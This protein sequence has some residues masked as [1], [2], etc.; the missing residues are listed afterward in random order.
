[1]N[2]PYRLDVRLAIVVTAVSAL[3]LF[4]AGTF[5]TLEFTRNQFALEER[6]L[7]A[8]V[9]ER[10]GLIRRGSDGAIA[11]D[12]SAEPDHVVEFAQARRQSGA[13][14]S[15]GY[16]VVNQ[17]GHILDRSRAKVPIGRPGPVTSKPVISSAPA[18]DGSGP[19]LVAELYAPQAGVWLRVTRARSDVTALTNSFFVRLVGNLGWAALAILLVLVLTA[20]AIVRISLQGLRRVAAQ[21]E[22]I[23][24]ENLRHE[25]LDGAAA[26][27]EIQPLILAF[28]QTLDSIQAGASAQRDFSIHAAH[29]LR[30]PLAD[31]RLRLEELAL[32]ADRMAA[33]RDVDAMARLLEQLLHVA[34]LDGEAPFHSIPL[35]LAALVSRLLLDAAPR[36]LSEGRFLEADGLDTPVQVIGDPTLVALVLRNLLENVRKHTPVR[37]R[38]TVRVRP[39][40]SL[41]V[42]DTGPGLPDT[43]QGPGF[44]RFLRGNDDARSGSGLGLSIIETAMARMGGTFRLDT[45]VSGSLFVLT[46][47]RA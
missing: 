32:G 9:V 4:A 39:D 18:L 36:L 1:M 20:V 17:Q 12:R 45:S 16:A 10:V 28:N 31:L 21:A 37:T 42:H 44:A 3:A 7:A 26:P 27:A 47:R 29:E 6:E 24:F 35:D 8:L 15:Y 34:R 22:R 40:G 25:R 14:A 30:T 33:M 19:L 23:T 41:T 46:F 43:F 13:A 38:V 11:L 2:R 5:V